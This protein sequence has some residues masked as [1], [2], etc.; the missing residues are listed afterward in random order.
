MLL[1]TCIVDN[2]YIGESALPYLALKSKF[3][4]RTK[5]KTAFD[6]LHS[7]FQALCSRNCQENV[8][9]IGHDDEIVNLELAG[10]DIRAQNVDQEFGH[11]RGLK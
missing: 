11:T 2:S 4:F 10:A 1:K 7:L 6:K 3:A 8:Q 5:R 9:V